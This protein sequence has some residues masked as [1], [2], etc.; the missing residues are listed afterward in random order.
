MKERARS[1]RKD[2]AAGL[3]ARRVEILRGGATMKRTFGFIFVGLLLGGCAVYAEPYPPGA[4]V[5]VAPA[6]VV[7]AP[8]YPHYPYYAYPRY[9][10]RGHPGWYRRGG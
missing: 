9:W 1:E 5:Y 7:V 4:G 3:A 10:Y 8:A 2:I 6:P